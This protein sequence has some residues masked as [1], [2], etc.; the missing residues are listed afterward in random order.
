[1]MSGFH[2]TYDFYC[3][4]G[5]VNMH[6]KFALLALLLALLLP[7]APVY[8]QPSAPDLLIPAGGGYGDVYEGIVTAMIERAGDDVVTI[9]VLPATYATDAYEISEEERAQN[10]EDA[11]VRRSG[12]E[13]ACL[14]A[15]PEGITCTATLAPIFVRADAEDAANLQYFGDDVDAVFILGGDQE[16]AMQV[17]AGTPVE[18][19]LAELYSRGVVVAGTSAGAAVQSRSMIAG[20]SGDDF[21]S[22]N[23]LNQGAVLLWQ[24]G[25]ERGLDFGVQD[26]ILDQ[27][28]FQRG[29]LGRLLEAISRP[30]APHVGV[31][32]DAYTGL[33]VENGTVFTDV[34][35][36]YTAAVLD[37]ETLGAAANVQYVG[38]QK[39]LRLRNVLVHLLAPGG[40]SYD[41]ASRAH[42]LAAPL[43]PTDAAVTERAFDGL[44]L[45]AGAG[46]LILAGRTTTPGEGD[47]YAR[48]LEAAGDGPLLV[49]A[50]G[51]PNDIAAQRAAER[52][53]ASLQAQSGAEV[54]TAV[55]SHRQSNAL[56]LDKPYAGIVVLGYDQVMIDPARLQAVADAWR[57]GTPLLLERAAAS[58][59]G[60]VYAQHRSPV[61]EDEVDT[62]QSMLSGSTTI[63][64]GLNLL[65]VAIETR[66]LET[67]RWGRFFSLAYTHNDQPAFAIGEDTALLIDQDGATVLG[68]GAVIA[69]DLR[70]ATLDLG[71]ND[72]FVAANGL[73][74]VFTSGKTVEPNG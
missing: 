8:A 71:S 55:L 47:I 19:A 52:A 53:A 69:L 32:V 9:T 25:D 49:I 70:A 50:A 33:R 13:E 57:A 63:A 2:P 39:T 17:L 54:E 15:A 41:L 56:A 72:G 51:W 66:V 4:E 27:H 74:D 59:A 36:L 24:S 16:I 60:A 48:L 28:F 43:A 3:K 21:D 40:S 26:A 30:D 45:P 12:I 29:R 73:L 42:S 62:Q 20:Y 18:D 46:P 6:R 65:P 1:M 34:F 11:E 38:D 31:G 61:W 35:G 7:A 37:A 14:E 23:A 10:I 68:T 64:D 22:T 5:T 44:A 58:I 67:N